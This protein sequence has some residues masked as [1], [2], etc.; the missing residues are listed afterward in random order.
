[1]ANG[2]KIKKWFLGKDQIQGKVRKKDKAD[3]MVVK[4]KTVKTSEISKAV[5]QRTV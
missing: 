1:M 4:K 5:P 3:C 2:F